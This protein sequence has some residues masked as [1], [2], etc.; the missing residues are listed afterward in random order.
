MNNLNITETRK[1]LGMAKRLKAA[2]NKHESYAQQANNIL[3]NSK[4]TWGEFGNPTTNASRN[5]VRKIER[6]ERM[7]NYTKRHLANV[8]VQM[9]NKFPMVS[10]MS[11]N[12]IIRNATRTIQRYEMALR[13]IHS[14]R[15]QTHGKRWQTNPKLH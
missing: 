9:M 11:H 6:L 14:G 10:N 13:N 3:K 12:N 15:Y 2:N 5:V 4:I 8:A 1:L 7:M